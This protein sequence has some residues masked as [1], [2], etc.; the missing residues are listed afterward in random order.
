MIVKVFWHSLISIYNIEIYYTLNK[1]IYI[2]NDLTNMETHN[3]TY[4][5]EG[6][7]TYHSW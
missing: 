7:F 6:A 4:H 3:K 5:K 2:N 1:H